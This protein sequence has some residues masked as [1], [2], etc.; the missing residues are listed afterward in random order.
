MAT[1]DLNTASLATRKTIAETLPS[2]DVVTELPATITDGRVKLYNG[3][4]WRGLL[5]GESSLAAGTPWPV[6][7]YKEFSLVCEVNADTD[8]V[9]KIIFF[10]DE[11]GINYQFGTPPTNIILIDFIFD[12][13][14][15]FQF[16]TW[17]HR[18]DEN[19]N[20]CD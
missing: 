10:K 15:A 13:R 4:M 2:Y 8:T 6:K 19:S 18:S 14:Y 3:T 20:A 5:E 7:G 17:N 12:E 16:T 1:I 11:I 9:T